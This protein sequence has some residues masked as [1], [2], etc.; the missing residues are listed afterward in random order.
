MCFA[1]APAPE[2][3]NPAKNS[4]VWQTSPAT[5][6]GYFTIGERAEPKTLNPVTA[7]DADFARSDRTSEWP[8]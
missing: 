6:V 5:T 3:P 4:L 7:T 2:K 1:A 8:I